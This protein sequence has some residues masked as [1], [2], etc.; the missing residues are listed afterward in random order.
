MDFAQ[1]TSFRA[2]LVRNLQPLIHKNDLQYLRMGINKVPQAKLDQMNQYLED[3]NTTQDQKTT[4]ALTVLSAGHIHFMKNKLK[5][6]FIMQSLYLLA[7]LGA[8]TSCIYSLKQE[9]EKQAWTSAAAIAV[10]YNVIDRHQKRFQNDT[11]DSHYFFKKLGEDKQLQQRLDTET[12][13]WFS[14][15]V[16][17]R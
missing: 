6:A 3:K 17:S 5:R 4:L 8:L 10:L 9:K 1:A 14:S 16:Q 11:K 13:K 7:G 15:Q 2:N 12:D